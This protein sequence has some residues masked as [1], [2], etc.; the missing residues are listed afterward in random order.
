MMSRLFISLEIPEGIKNE[1]ILLRNKIYGKFYEKIRWEKQEKLHLTLK[2]L[3]DTEDNRVDEIIERMYESLNLFNKFL[4]HFSEF[5]V[6]YRFNKPG[7]LW[8]G[9]ERNNNLDKLYQIVENSLSFLNPGKD[10]RCFNPHI[11]LLRIKGSEDMNKIKNFV[12]KIIPE[13]EFTA[14]KIVLY[15]SNLLKSGSVYEALDSF[16]LK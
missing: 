5:G 11:T 3:G 6:F 8:A 10:N 14:E 13:L 16:K 12:N 15:K 1:L 2:F 7:I 4:L 9:I